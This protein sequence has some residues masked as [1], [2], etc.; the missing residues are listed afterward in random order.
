IFERTFIIKFEQ[1]N[2]RFGKHELGPQSDGETRSDDCDLRSTARFTRLKM[3]EKSKNAARTR[4]EKENAEFL[5]LAKLLPL[6]AAIT[7][8]LD[9]ASVIRL[10]TSYLKMRDVFPD[11]LGD[12]WG[13]R[14]PPPSPHESA[15]REIGSLLL[16]TL[17]GFVFV[18]ACDGKVMYI[19]ETASTHLGLSQV[20]LTGNSIYDYIYQEDHEEMARIL[21]LSR[22]EEREIR[23]KLEFQQHNGHYF[24]STCTI[25]FP[26]WFFLRMKCVLAKRNAGLTTAGFKVIH[27]SGY[28]KVRLYNVDNASYETAI[29]NMGLCAVGHSLPPSG[30]TEIKM[31][32]NMFMF[33]A[34]QDLKL[35][36]LDVRVSPLTGYDPQDLIEKTLYQYIHYNDHDGMRC[37]HQKLLN[38]GQV[39]TRYYR[40][41]TKGGG[42]VWM[43]SYATLVHNTR[44]SRPHCIVSVNYVLS[45]V[46]SPELKLSLEQI[47]CGYSNREGS[48][49]VS[50]KQSASPLIAEATSPASSEHAVLNQSPVTACS[51]KSRSV[52]SSRSNRKSPYVTANGSV[53][54][55]SSESMF[56]SP[57]AIDSINNAF[58]NESAANGGF[59]TSNIA[60]FASKA[61][62]WPSTPRQ[63]HYP[64]YMYENSYVRPPESEVYCAED[65]QK[66]RLS[67]VGPP[68]Q[69]LLLNSSE[70]NYPTNSMQP[71]CT[72]DS[73]TV[74]K[75]PTSAESHVIHLPENYEPG[76]SLANDD[77]QELRPASLIMTPL[78]AEGRAMSDVLIRNTYEETETVT[79]IMPMFRSE[80]QSASEMS[81]NSSC[82]S[83]PI[84]CDRNAING[85]IMTSSEAKSSTSVIRQFTESPSTSPTYS[86]CSVT[87]QAHMHNSRYFTL[88]S[89][90]ANSA[91]SDAL[92]QTSD[93]H[94]GC[95]SGYTCN[96]R[97]G[98]NCNGTCVSPS[99]P[100]TESV[101]G[102]TSVIVDA[103]QYNFATSANSF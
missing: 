80:V 34:S 74:N 45:N 91:T 95:V 83:S 28:L 51:R 50:T 25:E 75:F 13:T 1:K 38:K 103:Q 5:E 84:I 101:A 17:D 92:N 35:I 29:Q 63:P 44:S 96:C 82:S 15:I 102:Y 59:I 2:Y 97:S 61:I 40:F 33:R 81:S 18:V 47:D 22:D 98:S 8:Q 79:A 11:G 37:C 64:S 27:C 7:S 42:W 41:L 49:Y 65:D 90:V 94:S 56:P 77:L 24:P 76:S 21:N 14:P 19:T 93:E 73:Y 39:T 23:Q 16:Q 48:A 3:K 26:R 53:G 30:I 100:V 46:Q 71:L 99:V 6:P 69:A 31:Y 78:R 9:K 12:G 54:S 52:R 88:A 43:Q 67:V 89:T 4:R 72:P 55:N 10:T 70:T 20:E 36:F 57:S 60:S 62:T 58:A 66:F 86:S 87:S 68:T 32:S 85:P